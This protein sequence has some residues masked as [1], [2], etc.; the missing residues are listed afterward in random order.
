LEQPKELAK[1]KECVEMTQG[2]A[3]FK[4]ALLKNRGEGD[5]SLTATVEVEVI[6]GIMKSL[7]GSWVGRLG[8]GV[9]VRALQTKL[10]LAGFPMVR[11]V[12]MGGDFV[13]ISSN[14]GEEL[15]GPMCKKGW[16][17]GLLYDL[18]R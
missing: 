12:T 1:K 9:E 7:E 2:S 10:W 3:S 18:K 11:V 6:S 14:T 8:D 13:L 4:H 5:S 17:G 16:W 15:R